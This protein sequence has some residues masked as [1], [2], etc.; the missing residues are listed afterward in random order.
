MRSVV[1]H[2]LAFCDRQETSAMYDPRRFGPRVYATNRICMLRIP[3][4]D[5]HPDLAA[6][7]PIK[8]Q[9]LEKWD[10]I[11][12]SARER[13]AA[14]LRL[15]ELP[16][17]IPCYFC[18]GTGNVGACPHCDLGLF[19]HGGNDYECLNCRGAGQSKHIDGDQVCHQC[20]GLGED[21]E[22]FVTLGS[23]IFTRRYLALI[24][25]LPGIRI[26]EP[27]EALDAPVYFSSTIG[28]GVIMP[29]RFIKDHSC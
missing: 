3:L 4:Q 24:A 16:A 23:T 27:I 9:N 21:P 17:P 10:L 2:L 5:D 1:E 25:A 8:E 20:G 26:A 29:C 11:I 7:Q 6:H 19:E 28:D 22:Q 18:S 15:P 12:D 14:Y 13:A